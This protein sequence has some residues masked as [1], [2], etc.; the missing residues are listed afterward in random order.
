MRNKHK[1]S[2]LHADKK[3]FLLDVDINCSSVM[4]YRHNWAN[5]HMHT[6]K[7]PVLHMWVHTYTT[8]WNHSPRVQATQW[9]THWKMNT[10]QDNPPPPVSLFCTFDD[11]D[12]L[13]WYFS[14][15]IS[16]AF[17]SPIVSILY[18]VKSLFS[19]AQVWSHLALTSLRGYRITKTM[20]HE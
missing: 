18:W 19:C 5:N 12:V 10:E 14:Y 9:H 4:T 13:C 20:V 8:V 7:Y 3:L 11:D 15:D 16:C 6:E 1:M 2:G 17:E